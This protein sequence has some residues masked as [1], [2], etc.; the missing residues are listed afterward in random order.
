MD[1]S[2]VVQRPE[3][4]ENARTRPSEKPPG[5]PYHAAN[6]PPQTNPAAAMAP[7]PMG[8]VQSRHFAPEQGAGKPGY[9][10]DSAQAG[11]A[12][13][14]PSAASNAMPRSM[15]MR[16]ETSAAPKAKPP[17]TAGAMP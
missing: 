5:Y 1:A 14:G 9:P 12:G 8:F 10:S 3:A 6:R 4:A 7:S 15:S 2:V 11:F 17:S 16:S 13:A